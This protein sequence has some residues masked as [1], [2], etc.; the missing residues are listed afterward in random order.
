M[1]LL[2]AGSAEIAPIVVQAPDCRIKIVQAKGP[3]RGCERPVVNKNSVRATMWGDL[4]I[5]CRRWP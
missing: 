1:V 4:R 3:E 5:R 2:A